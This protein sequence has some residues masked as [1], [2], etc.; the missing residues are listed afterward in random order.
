MVNLTPP[1]I[2]PHDLEVTPQQRGDIERADAVLYLGSGFQPQVEDTVAELGEDVETV[3]LLGVVELLPVTAPLAG[4]QGEVDGEVVAGNKDPHAWV[5]PRVFTS[6]VEEVTATLTAV[7]PDR[8]ADFEAAGAEYVA[9]LAALDAEFAAGLTGC[10]STAVV[11]S[12][13]AFEYLARDYGLTQIPI[14]G[15]SPEQEPDPRTLEAIAAAAREQNVTTVFFEDVL[16]PNL[17]ET[18]AEEIGATT[19]LLSPI[20][21]IPQ[22]DID[23]G[24]TYLTIQRDNLERLVRGLRCGG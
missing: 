11:T 15:I 13:R 21:T 10:A 14:G 17:S 9:E 1:G 20:E 24:A 8:A 4:I 19:D 2:G 16:P 23:A 5:S 7:V 3:D 18:V 12:H 22:E 6:M